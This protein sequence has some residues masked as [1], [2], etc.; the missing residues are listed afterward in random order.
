MLIN[1]SEDAKVRARTLRK[2]MTLPERLL[3]G[4]LRNRKYGW[5]VRRQHPIG[6][7]TL[8]FF[9]EEHLI[10]IEID[11]KSHGVRETEDCKRTAFLAIYGVTTIRVSAAAVLR[12]AHEVAYSIAMSVR[13]R[14][15][16]SPQV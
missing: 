3:W 6:Q 2:R 15:Q 13:E 4:A 11:G 9:I 16:S 8:D 7:Y 14:S 10:D 1:S 5:K 12:D